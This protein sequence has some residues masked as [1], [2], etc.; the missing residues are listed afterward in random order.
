MSI[1]RNISIAAGLVT[2]VGVI[3]KFGKSVAD[4][5]FHEMKFN[6]DPQSLGVK[7]G[8]LSTDVWAD[9]IVD[10]NYRTD[11]EIKNLH[12]S[13]FYKDDNGTLKEL[14]H[15]PPNSRKYLLTK[16]TRT[17]IE[18]I[19]LSIG[20]LSIPS[21]VSSFTN[22]EGERLKFVVSGKINGLPLSTSYWY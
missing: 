17:K 8:I 9:L 21:G 13:I 16:G 5:F 19:K 14:G 6:I 4:N 12:L 15:T 22:K 10:N 20:T 2:A 1:V 18:A 3:S 11:L 7:F